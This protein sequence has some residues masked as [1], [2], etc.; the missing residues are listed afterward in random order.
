[1]R[2]FRSPCMLFAA[3]GQLFAGGGAYRE[4]RS[5][6]NGA[7]PEPGEVGKDW[8]REGNRRRRAFACGDEKSAA[9]VD[10]KTSSHD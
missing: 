10:A 3:S 9:I 6:G 4:M 5:R 2:D 1:M 8:R 7:V